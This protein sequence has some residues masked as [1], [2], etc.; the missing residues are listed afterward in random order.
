MKR[1]GRPTKMQSIDKR[2]RKET[3]I[4]LYEKGIEMARIARI[5]EMS[6]QNV[7]GIINNKD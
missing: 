3:I 2:V 6:V 7:W 4:Y 5:F 1:N